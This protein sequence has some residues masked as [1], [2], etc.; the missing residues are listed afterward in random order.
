MQQSLSV[1]GECLDSPRYPI[2]FPLAAAFEGGSIV[3]LLGMK[4]YIDRNQDI[5][6][7]GFARKPDAET[8]AEEGERESSVDEEQRHA[9]ADKMPGALLSRSN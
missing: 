8:D 7:Y 3:A 5:L 9:T 4:V 1:H 2:G 6:E